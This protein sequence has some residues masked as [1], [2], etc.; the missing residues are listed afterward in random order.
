MSHNN[1]DNLELLRSARDK[2]L[3]KPAAYSCI[4]EFTDSFPK[5][6]ASTFVQQIFLVTQSAW[7]PEEP[8]S[9][10]YTEHYKKSILSTLR[11][12]IGKI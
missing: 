4:T 5:K 3:F 10:I 6:K 8:Y 1:E 11:Q 9:Q 2:L 12:S 7:Q